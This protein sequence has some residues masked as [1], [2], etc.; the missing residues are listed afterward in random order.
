MRR[1]SARSSDTNSTSDALSQPR[2]RSQPSR[3]VDELKPELPVVLPLLLAVAPRLTM[4]CLSR[5]RAIAPALVVSRL[6]A[7]LRR[8][9]LFDA[10]NPGREE[11]NGR[12]S[13]SDP[14]EMLTRSLGHELVDVPVAGR[15]RLL[16][17]LEVHLERGAPVTDL[18][19][20]FRA[21]SDVSSRIAARETLR[22]LAGPSNQLASVVIP[23]SAQRLAGNACH[24]EPFEAIATVA[25]FAESLVWAATAPTS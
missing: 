17:A 20:G 16:A 15:D 22:P 9:P 25:T 14:A 1:R 8:G 2:R 4:E 24:R 13:T 19:C 12:A 21:R 3:W 10:A 6:R 23:C 5:H 7:L 11:V 18:P